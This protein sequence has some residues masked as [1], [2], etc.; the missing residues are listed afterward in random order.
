MR[1]L[2][3]GS[4]R[5]EGDARAGE[6]FDERAG[7]VGSGCDEATTHVFEDANTGSNMKPDNPIGDA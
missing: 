2:D 6:P 1:A 5:F 4:A 7:E 3:G